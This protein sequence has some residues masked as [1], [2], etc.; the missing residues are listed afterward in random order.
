VAAF[1][2]VGLFVKYD[3]L[4]FTPEHRFLIASQGSAASRLSQ[5]WL[6]LRFSWQEFAIA[7]VLLGA[8]R[9]LARRWPAPRLGLRRALGG[10]RGCLLLASLF[11]VLGIVY[12]AVYQ[13]H[14]ALEEL[15]WAGWLSQMVASLGLAS[16]PSV[17]FGVALCLGVYLWLPGLTARFA[18]R[19]STAACLLPLALGVITGIGGRP[20]LSEARLEPNPTLWLLFGA[21]PSYDHV[22][23]GESVEAIGTRTRLHRTTETP[24]NVILVILES[25]PASALASYNPG[26]AAGRRLL[27]TFGADVTVFEQVFAVVPNSTGSLFSVLRGT[28]PLPDVE[29]A[30]RASAAVPTLTELLKRE[31]GFFTELLLSGLTDELMMSVARPGFDRVLTG[32]SEWPGKDTYARLPWGYD[33]RMVFD[34]AHRFLRRQ[35]PDAAPF[36][37]VL[38]A[39]NPHVPYSS[40]L[41]PGL[42]GDADPK[43]RHRTLVQHDMNLLTDLYASMKQSGLAETTA[44]IA[45][46]DHGEAFD[47]HPGNHTHAS[48]LFSENVHVPLLLIHPRRLGLPP[49]LGQLGTLEDILPT[50]CDLIGLPVAPRSGMSLL[51]DAPDRIVLSATDYGPGQIALRDSRYTYMLSRTGRELLFYRPTDPLEQADLHGTLP[52]VTARFRARLTHR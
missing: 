16:F 36:L 40:G 26:E 49:R 29:A 37:L 30:M 38:Y 46:G 44:L 42:S 47:E 3:E 27:D 8:I 12:Y 39:N 20:N 52:D 22:P 48:Y 21:R 19:V 18:T 25:T 43:R 2:I 7:A 28:S 4:L 5:V 32:E 10:L 35:T 50:I 41:I 17:L 9:L 11:S 23:S 31:R 13:T 34:E 45:Y 6:A 14:I 1:L 24:R 51:F 33:D 15:R